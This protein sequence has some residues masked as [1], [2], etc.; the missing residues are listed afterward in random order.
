VLYKPVTFDQ[1]KRKLKTFLNSSFHIF[2]AAK[3]QR[4][5]G[6]AGKAGSF[7]KGKFGSD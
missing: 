2:F 1:S 4:D 7:K 3:T 5:S 6:G